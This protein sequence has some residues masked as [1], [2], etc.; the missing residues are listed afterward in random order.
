MPITT[1]WRKETDMHR[2]GYAEGIGIRV[3]FEKHAARRR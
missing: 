1:L 2:I 3:L